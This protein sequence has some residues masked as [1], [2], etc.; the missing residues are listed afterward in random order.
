MIIHYQLR[1]TDQLYKLII[2]W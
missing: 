2:T 1:N